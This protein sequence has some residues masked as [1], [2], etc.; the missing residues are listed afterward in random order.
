LW[1]VQGGWAGKARDTLAHLRV[2]AGNHPDDT[3]I[4]EPVGELSHKSSTFR[5]WWA[6]HEVRERSHGRKAFN[7]PLVGALVLDFESMRLPDDPDQTLVMYTVEPGSVSETAL[8]QLVA[9]SD[10]PSSALESIPSGS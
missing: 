4:T 7:H 2:D 9:E 8:R 5:R 3:A 10:L 1:R 6:D